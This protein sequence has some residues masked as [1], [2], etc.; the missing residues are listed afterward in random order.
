MNKYVKFISSQL[1]FRISYKLLAGVVPKTVSIN[2]PYG[3]IGNFG[4]LSS[5]NFFVRLE[6]SLVSLRSPIVLFY[7]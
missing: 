4:K 7:S 3:I 2:G 1:F 5:R 6:V